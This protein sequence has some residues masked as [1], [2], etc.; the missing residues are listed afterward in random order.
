MKKEKTVFEK[1]IDREIPADI[2]Y[3]DE[4]IIAFLDAFPFEKGHLLVVPKKVY[5][6]VWEIPEEEFLELQ[7]VVLK[8]AQKIYQEFPEAG[9]NIFQNNKKIAHQVVPHVHFHICPRFT[10][11]D[12]YQHGGVNY[13]DQGEKNKYIEKLR[14]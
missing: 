12:L 13:K 4:N 11:K 9:L 8:F 14:F 5:E 6:F 2:L 10:E 1:I 3:E 7:K